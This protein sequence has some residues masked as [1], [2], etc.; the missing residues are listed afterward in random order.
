MKKITKIALGLGLVLS[1]TACGN[2]KD[3]T[4]SNSNASNQAKTEDRFAD[5][6]EIKIG[7]C[8]EK[9]EV[10][11]DIAKRFEKDTGK[12]IKIVSFSD[13]NQPNEALKAGDI[14]LNAF[15][16]KKFLED[17]NKSHKTDIVAVGDTLLAPM[18]IYS[19]K[20]KDVKEIKDGDKI[21]IPNDPTNGARA[22]FLLQSAG[23]IE[24]DGKEGDAITVADIKENPKN[25]EIIE[26][27]ASQTARN[28]TEVAAS[29]INSGV[30]VDAGFVPTEDAIYLEDKDDPAKAI[31]VNI[32][33][34]RKEDKDSKTVENFIKNYYQTDETK[35]LVEKETKGSEIPAWK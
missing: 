31:Y 23:L 25:L 24:V 21:A 12:K 7:V 11:E 4:N 13:Y 34:A 6:K 29:V 20:I 8:G 5:A 1:L 30:A 33:A 9:N 3:D 19:D 28:L 18:G 16:H 2:K 15:Q 26:L 17:Y 35:K 22:L 27:D 32:I 14:D 10:L